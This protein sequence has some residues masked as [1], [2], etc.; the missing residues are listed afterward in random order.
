MGSSNVNKLTKNSI[1][2][3]YDADFENAKALAACKLS[4]RKDLENQWLESTLDEMKAFQRGF[5]QRKKKWEYPYSFYQLLKTGVCKIRD[6]GS[7]MT[8]FLFFIIFRL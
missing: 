1:D 8:F 6:A 5:I 4:E 3:Y 2:K 7:A